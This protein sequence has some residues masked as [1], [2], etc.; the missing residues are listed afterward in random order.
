[1]K[2]SGF[3]IQSSIAAVLIGATA[4][5]G[6][7]EKKAP[8]K[9]KGAPKTKA[10]VPADA[11]TSQINLETALRL[12]GAQNL[13]VQIAR[14]RVKEAKAQ[15]EQAREQFFPWIAPGLGYKRHDGNIQDVSGNIFE[16]F[17]GGRLLRT[18]PCAG[19]LGCRAGGFAYFAGI[20]RAG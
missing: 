13:D 15:H 6:A 18:G 9:K 17:P 1:M 16:A 20:R 7:A 5:C 14:E 4:I 19:C 12:A 11:H 3:S 8:A 10:G 2:F